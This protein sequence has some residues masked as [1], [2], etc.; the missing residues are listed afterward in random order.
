MPVIHP[1]YV[2]DAALPATC[3]VYLLTLQEKSKKRGVKNEKDLLPT[4]AVHSIPAYD[5]KR[6]CP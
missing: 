5:A 4:C 1:Q 6:L 2:V 3:R